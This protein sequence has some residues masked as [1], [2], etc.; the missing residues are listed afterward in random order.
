YVYRFL[1]LNII[2][3]DLQPGQGISE[4]DVANQ[5]QVSRTPVRE[6]F[7]KLSQENLLDI[8][9]QKGTYVSLIDTD[10]VEES[11]FA[12]EILEREIVRQA[13]ITFPAEALFQLQSA[14]ALQELCIREKDYHRFFQQDEAMHGMIFKGCK[15]SR[16]WNMLQSMNAH[17]NRVRILNLKDRAFEWE[18]LILQ[19]KDLVRAISESDAELGKRTIDLHLNKVVVDLE[20]L[21]R[22]HNAWFL[23]IK[24]PTFSLLAK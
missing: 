13:C 6:A 20:H 4:Q 18:Q 19:H 12:R 17:Y 21:R 24:M 14:L 15:K 9:P 5:L 3:L 11:K 7:I 23:Q 10:Q 22:E 1:K 16:I 8:V 2:N